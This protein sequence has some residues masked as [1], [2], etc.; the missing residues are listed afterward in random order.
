MAS[1]P[2]QQLP[3]QK[4]P[5]P[6]PLSSL[7]TLAIKKAADIAVS[8]DDQQRAALRSQISN[9]SPDG[10]AT[11]LRLVEEHIEEAMSRLVLR[12]VLFFTIS[13]LEAA[14]KTVYFLGC[15]QRAAE[16]RSIGQFIRLAAIY[17]LT[18]STGLPLLLSVTHLPNM[19]GLRNLPLAI[20]IYRLIGRQLTHQS[21]CLNLEQDASGAYWIG[22]GRVFRAVPLGELPA[23]HPYAEGY[24]RGDPVIRDGITLHRSFSSYLLCCLVYWWSHQGGVHRTTVKTTADRRSASRQSL[25]TG[26]IPQQMGIVADRQDDGNDARLVVVSGFR[27]PDTVAAHLEIQA[28]SITLTTTE[29]AVAHAPAPLSTRFPVS[30]PL[31][32]RVLK[33]F[34]LVINDLLK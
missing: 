12:D 13:D 5:S 17:R 31:W 8:G 7:L 4:P 22:T 14:L 33:Q 30:V 11:M 21:D 28:D 10:L 1:Q 15:Q 24:Q 3:D 6:P 26:H 25:P 20:A 29:S 16:W 19:W 9:S 32:R 23:N 27:P 18:P 2:T 34:D